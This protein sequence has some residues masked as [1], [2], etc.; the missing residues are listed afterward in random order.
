MLSHQ[1]KDYLCPFC[2]WL[3][4]NETEYKQN[5]DIVF[6]NDKVTAFISPKWWVNNPGHVIVI[7]NHHIENLYSITDKELSEVYRTVKQVAVA[8]RNSYENC[9]GTSTRQHN[10]PSGN[11]DVWH[12]HTHVFP[13]YEN[14]K[15]YQNHEEKRFVE[16]SERKV[17]ADVLRAYLK[18]E[19]REGV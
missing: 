10:E 6:Q 13:R 7:P 19:F 15:L 9:T 12:F 1:P 8:I 11:Q 17:Y 5:S 16:P 18:K 4:G 2:D 3:S 14:D